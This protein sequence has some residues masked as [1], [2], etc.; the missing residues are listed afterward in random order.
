MFEPT[1]VG[2]GAS[3]L[4]RRHIGQSV[5][6]PIAGGLPM[7]FYNMFKI[8]YLNVSLIFSRAGI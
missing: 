6:M 3:A 8:N 5:V 7:H 1:H 2:H 4:D